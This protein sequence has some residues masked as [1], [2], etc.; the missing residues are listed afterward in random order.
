VA[1]PLIQYGL[2]HSAGFS[3]RIA[4]TSI[5]NRDSLAGRAPAARVEENVRLNLGIWNERGD[6]IG[7]HNLPD[8]PMLD[9][10][11]GAAFVM[12]A[13]LILARMRDRRA[14]LLVLWV[15]VALTPG[16]FSIEAP[17]AVRTVEVIGP[18]M[19]L[20]SIGA[21]GLANWG[22][23]QP[24]HNNSRQLVQMLGLGLLTGALALNVTRYFVTWPAAPKAYEEFFVAETHLGE[25]V[26][27]LASE[28][29]LQASGYRIF[30][31]ES[32]AK[33]D[34]LRYL[35]TGIELRTFGDAPQA[36]LASERS[37]LIDDSDQQA[38]DR[39]IGHDMELLGSGPISPLTGRP[40]F[41]IYGRGAEARQAVARA[42]AP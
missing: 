33:S 9:P 16:I 42:L 19:L 1:W 27:R 4:Q 8:A 26:Q 32:A 11:T 37:L 28:P 24:W 17:H 14:L 23:C 31:P 10:L 7:R 12:G 15:G 25:V 21:C 20:A 3:Q 5:F 39:L 36:T 34:V 40:E 29:G 30:V 35:T 2:T 18:T 22:A 6:R 38:A 13:G 41:A